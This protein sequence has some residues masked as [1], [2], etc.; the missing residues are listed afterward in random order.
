MELSI[1]ERLSRYISEQFPRDKR[2]AVV[3]M[4]YKTNEILALVSM[5]QF[6]PTDMDSALVDEAAG[7]L[8][9][10]ATQGLYPPGSTFK[11]VT[12]ASASGGNSSKLRLF[13]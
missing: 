13:S 9:N 6:D 10:R 4:N 8:V 7:A 3:V 2:G 5:P 1:S 12:M 11:I